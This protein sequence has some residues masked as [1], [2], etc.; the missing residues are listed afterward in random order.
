MGDSKRR[1]Y[2]WVP[3]RRQAISVLVMAELALAAA[4]PL[5][6]PGWLAWTGS[7]LAVVY[8]LFGEWLY[9]WGRQVALAAAEARRQQAG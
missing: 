6:V 2:S 1:F 5:Q 4:L 7:I 8:L 3:V 9:Q